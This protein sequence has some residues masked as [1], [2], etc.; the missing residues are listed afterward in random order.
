MMMMI[1]IIWHLINETSLNRLYLT[2]RCEE[3]QCKVIHQ[4][5]GLARAQVGVA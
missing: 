4:N 1:I 3:H 2:L 5:Y